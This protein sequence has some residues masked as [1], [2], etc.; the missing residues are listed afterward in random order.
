MS[1]NRKDIQFCECCGEWSEHEI[2]TETVTDRLGNCV[3]DYIES[4]CLNCGC[5]Q[6]IQELYDYCSMI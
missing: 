3:Y 1:K 5:V 4:E 6:E 2:F